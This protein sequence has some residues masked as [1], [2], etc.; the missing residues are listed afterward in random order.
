MEQN[1]N[2]KLLNY[3]E[4]HQLVS[5]RQYNFRHS[6]AEAIDSKGEALAVSLNI[7]QAFDRVWHRA[8]LSKLP[9]S[10]GLPTKLCN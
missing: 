9:S 8:L 5:D 2:A 1:I 4:E 3:L 10:Y 6:R 7:A